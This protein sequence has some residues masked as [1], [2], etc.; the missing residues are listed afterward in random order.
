M[1]DGNRVFVDRLDEM[2]TA[3]TAKQST[4]SPPKD[5]KEAKPNYPKTKEQQK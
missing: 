2:A 5:D 4:G 1:V 3:K